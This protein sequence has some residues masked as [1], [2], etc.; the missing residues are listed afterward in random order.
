MNNN[1]MTK[2]I[3]F[4]KHRL[5]ALI[6]PNRCRDFP[7]KLFHINKKPFRALSTVKV[8]SSSNYSVFDF[9]TLSELQTKA[10]KH[11]SNIDVFGTLQKD[12][13]GNKLYKFITYSQFDTI[14]KEYRKAFFY[15]PLTADFNSQN[16]DHS[17]STVGIR[18]N[19]KIAIISNNRMEW[20]AVCYSAMGIGAQI[21]PM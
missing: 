17:P 20:A 1:L 14:V 2:S 21:V 15:L 6:Q 12:E 5:N 13:Q 19:D 8:Q 16:V 4:R 18:K 11:F 10:T 3:L 7:L 9:E